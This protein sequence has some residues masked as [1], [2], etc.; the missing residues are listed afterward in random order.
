MSKSVE[1]KFLTKLLVVLGM[2]EALVPPSTFADSAVAMETDNAADLE[3]EHILRNLLDG[4][5]FVEESGSNPSIL[6][7]LSR[8]LELVWKFNV[9]QVCQL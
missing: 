8:C 6:S 2:E 1:F 3:L 7:T 5:H 4:D 9:Y